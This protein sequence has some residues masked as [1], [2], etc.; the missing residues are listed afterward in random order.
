[1]STRAHFGRT[2]AAYLLGKIDVPCRF[3][4]QS[5]LQFQSR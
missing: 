4:Q 5:F 3:Y 1:M 2:L